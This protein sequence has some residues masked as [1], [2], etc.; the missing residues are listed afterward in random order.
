MAKVRWKLRS[1]MAERK[2]SNAVLGR[3]V[4]KHET[5]IS[6]LRQRDT[7]PA[8]GNDEIETLR[9]QINKLAGAEYPECKLSDLVEVDESD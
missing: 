9:L 2:I 6:R 3:A 5:T 4:G 1:V 7:L 8:I